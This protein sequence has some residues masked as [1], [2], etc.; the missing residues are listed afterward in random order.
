MSLLRMKF[1]SRRHRVLA[2]MSL[3]GIPDINKVFIKEVK[4]KKFDVNDGFK[5]HKEWMLDT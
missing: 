1:S 4:V 2:E 5:E 3:R